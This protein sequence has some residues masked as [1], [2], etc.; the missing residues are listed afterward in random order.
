MAVLSA[1]SVGRVGAVETV[2]APVADTV[3]FR[4]PPLPLPSFLD[5]LAGPERQ[6]TGSALLGPVVPSRPLT[7]IVLPVDAAGSAYALESGCADLLPM[8]LGIELA[9]E[10]PI[11]EVDRT[12]MREVVQDQI[13]SGLLSSD[14]NKLALGRVLGGRLLIFARFTAIGVM[15]KIA[16]RAVDVE[17]TLPLPVGLLDAPPGST[18]D[19]VAPLVADALWTEI[20]KAYP[21]QGRLLPKAAGA[22]EVNIGTQVGVTKDTV[23][24]LL[25][26][27]GSNPVRDA[28]VTV[29]GAPSQ[30]SATVTVEGVEGENPEEEDG[31][32]YVRARSE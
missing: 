9:A 22:F 26:G 27:P 1:V 14:S 19:E 16:L 15:D 3:R 18:V 11:T 7:F 21:I 30:N 17:S 10:R 28:S 29:I 24:D 13:L 2:P 32:W 6:A 25:L 5:R 8:L 20:A 31:S 4:V 12:L 23:F